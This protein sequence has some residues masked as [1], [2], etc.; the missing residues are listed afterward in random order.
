[1]G[2]GIEKKLD[3]PAFLNY[4]LRSKNGKLKGRGEM[5]RD[6]HGRTF[7]YQYDGKGKAISKQIFDKSGKELEEK[8]VLG[9][10]TYVPK[11]NEEENS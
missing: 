7:V 10:T 1:M 2:N 11:I 5:K 4:E 6:K 3:I 9:I 8:R